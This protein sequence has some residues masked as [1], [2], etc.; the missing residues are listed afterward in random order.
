MPLF[1]GQRMNLLPKI[2]SASVKL[3]RTHTV[4]VN[5]AG[6]VKSREEDE[7]TLMTSGSARASR[8]IINS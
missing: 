2:S 5:G 6:E 1:D 8:D 3:V 4:I 7:T